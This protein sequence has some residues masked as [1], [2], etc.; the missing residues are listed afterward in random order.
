MKLIAVSDYVK[1]YDDGKDWVIV[2]ALGEQ[3][4]FPKKEYPH[5]DVAV[6]TKYGFTLVPG[7]KTTAKEGLDEIAGQE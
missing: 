6:I 2:N 7:A 1:F 3:Q 4:R 5:H